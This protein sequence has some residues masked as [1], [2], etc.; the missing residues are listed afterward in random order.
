[1]KYF[2]LCFS[3]MAGTLVKAQQNLV[4]N[5]SFEEYSD[6]PG[7]ASE[8]YKTTAWFSPTNATPDYFNGNLSCPLSAGSVPKNELGFQYARTGTAY[9]G[10]FIEGN[11]SANH[12]D[13]PYREYIETKLLEPLKAGYNYKVEFFVSI[14]KYDSDPIAGPSSWIFLDATDGVGAYLSMESLI[15]HSNFPAYGEPLNITP[16]IQNPKGNV[17]HDT[18]TINGRTDWMNISGIYK[19]NDNEEFLTIGGF[20]PDSLSRVELSSYPHDPAWYACYYYIDD[21]SVTCLNCDSVYV[22]PN[23]VFIPDAFSPNGDGNNDVLF[24][25]GNNIK[26]M[27]IAIYDRWGEK[28]FE[29][30]D[31]STG[32]D[33]TY[34]G[35]ELNSSVFMY[36][37]TWKYLDG[38]EFRQKGDITLVH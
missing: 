36:Y 19:A 25:R 8:L 22:P 11:T 32:W 20:T 24:V 27:H 16:Q 17:L 12:I 28:V 13:P 14:C 10:F 21:V 4:P 5:P 35:K 29:S 31:Q 26:T 9:A 7:G 38:G 34:K 23:E 15:G 33:G 3:I 18:T 37:C 6:C 1:M 2:L 30:N